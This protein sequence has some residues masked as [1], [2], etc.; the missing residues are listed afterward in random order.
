VQITNKEI[1]NIENLSIGYSSKKGQITV[2]SNINITLKKGKL[3]CLLGKNGIGKSTFLRTITKVQPKLK[4]SIKILDTNI[5]SID[6]HN[7]AK[8]LSLVLT[9]PMPENNLSVFELVALGRQPYTNWLGTLQKE[10]YIYINKALEQTNT[11]HLKDAK[12]FE[13]SDG[14]LQKV[15][16]ARALAQNTDLIILDEPTTHL[17]MHQ[18]IETFTLLK[19][20]VEGLNKTIIFS[21]H[22]INLALQL[23]NELWLM[24]P[25]GFISGNTEKL[26][27]SNAVQQLFDSDLIE[28]NKTLKQFTLKVVS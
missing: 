16:I 7:L 10:D 14:Q 24:T 18:T 12:C 1:I 9:E 13:L 20:L 2:G 4:G 27:Q 28:F 8:L 21:T 25:Q 26:M 23:A 6:N 5:D 11:T 19:K 22:H 3:V 15:M 17:D